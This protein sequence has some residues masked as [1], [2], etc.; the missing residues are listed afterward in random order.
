MQSDNCT[1]LWAIIGCGPNSGNLVTPGAWTGPLLMTIPILSFMFM[2]SNVVWT[3]GYKASL[4]VALEILS[5]SVHISATHTSTN[6][7]TGGSRRVHGATK[8][9]R[10]DTMQ[11]N[12]IV[13]T[14]DM[15]KCN[16]MSI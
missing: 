8:N 15:M 2:S 12:N 5:D 14:R 4:C 3:P 9:T 16:E 7:T 10:R 6:K 13:I 1:Q 11:V